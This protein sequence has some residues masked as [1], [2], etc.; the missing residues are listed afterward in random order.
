LGKGASQTRSINNSLNA[1]D[2]KPL[3]VQAKGKKLKTSGLG[4]KWSPDRS[5]WR[6]ANR[7]ERGKKWLSQDHKRVRASL[8]S[9]CED[10]G[11]TRLRPRKERWGIIGGW[12][13]RFTLCRNSRGRW[14]DQWLRD[15]GHRVIKGVVG[16]VEKG[17]G[18]KLGKEKV[19]TATLGGRKPKRLCASNVGDRSLLTGRVEGNSGEGKLCE[20][21][22]KGRIHAP[23]VK[24]RPRNSRRPR[25]GRLLRRGC[26]RIAGA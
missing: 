11:G 26:V 7:A 8:G 23:E 22:V 6:K 9:L 20:T 10:R 14:S 4:R 15:E 19:F 2:K 17:R 5:K 13:C 24:R 3:V 16:H 1:D 12:K 25:R 21:P 18:E